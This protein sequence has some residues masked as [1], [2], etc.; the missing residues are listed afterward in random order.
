MLS[1]SFIHQA[2]LQ[3]WPKHCSDQKTSGL[4]VTEWCYQNNLSLHKFSYRKHLPFLRP[5]AQVVQLVQ[6]VKSIHVPQ[7]KKGDI[8]IELNSL[9]SEDLF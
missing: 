9:A 7:Y 8:T 6:L 4:T 5:I 2:K 3:E 1:K